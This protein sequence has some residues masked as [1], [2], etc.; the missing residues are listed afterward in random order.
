ML[1]VV[2]SEPDPTLTD[3]D[4]RERLRA[5]RRAEED[6]SFQR[7]I[8][9]G[10]IDV[11]RSEILAR[12]DRGRGVDHVVGDLDDL[13]A[14]LKEALTHKGPP[15][16]EAELA[17]FGHAD[18]GAGAP[19]TVEDELPDLT[20]L[21]DS[22]LAGLV[23]SLGDEERRTSAERQEL[24]RALDVLRASHVARLQ[25]KFAGDGG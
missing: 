22:D 11:V 13:V 12:V 7:R 18:D 2:T 10:R 21:S 14:R 24:H 8:L 16:I 1:S 17:E 6:L 23:R 20:E 15:P 3:D 19:V 4:V 25:K 9:H 5:A